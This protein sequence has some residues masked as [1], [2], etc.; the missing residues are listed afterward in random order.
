M[1]LLSIRARRSSL[2]LPSCDLM[3]R[4][5]FFLSADKTTINLVPVLSMFL[6]L[7]L[8]GS[9]RKHLKNELKAE[10]GVDFIPSTALA[11]SFHARVFIWDQPDLLSRISL[12]F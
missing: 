8:T 3:Q 10:H 4:S 11:T 7:T 5:S 1:Y 9:A 6:G 12:F 2:D